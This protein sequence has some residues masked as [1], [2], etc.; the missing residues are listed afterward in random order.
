[1]EEKEKWQQW[2]WGV[3]RIYSMTLCITVLL[4]SRFCRIWKVMIFVIYYENWL[5]F[6]R[7]VSWRS[8][9]ISGSKYCVCIPPL[10]AALATCSTCKPPDLQML[11]PPALPS[12]SWPLSAC[13]CTA[14]E[15]LWLWDTENRRGSG[16]ES[17]SLA[18]QERLQNLGCILVLMEVKFAS[19]NSYQLLGQKNNQL[20]ITVLEAWPFRAIFRDLNNNDNN[21]AIVSY[22]LLNIP[23]LAS[24]RFMPSCRALRLIQNYTEFCIWRN[25]DS[26]QYTLLL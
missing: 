2:G 12:A 13:F 7:Q 8:F 10:R 5:K 24:G 18:R 26:I 16:G 3:R 21:I 17:S 14:R 15:G 22:L 1:M 9:L 11:G 25:T 6:Q 4:Q 23:R 19:N 20:A